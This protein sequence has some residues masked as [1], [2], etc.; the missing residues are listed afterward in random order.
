VPPLNPIPNAKCSDHHLAVQMVRATAPFLH[1]FLQARVRHI[2]EMR[3]RDTILV[4]G[5]GRPS[6]HRFDSPDQS[7]VQIWYFC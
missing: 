5:P 3:S 2:K 1:A 7:L 4:H 6:M